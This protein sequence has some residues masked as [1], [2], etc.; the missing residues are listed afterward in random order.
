[1]TSFFQRRNKKVLVIRRTRCLSLVVKTT[2]FSHSFI[3]D[4]EA[5]KNEAIA[6]TNARHR[7]SKRKKDMHRVEFGLL[8]WPEVDLQFLSDQPEWPES[9]NANLKSAAQGK[10]YRFSRKH[11]KKAR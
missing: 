11:S 6:G 4:L 7:R 3:K 2:D 9:E 8:G 5:S 10:S 1:M